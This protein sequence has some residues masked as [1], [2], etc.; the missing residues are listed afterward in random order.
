MTEV[1]KQDVIS[2]MYD[3]Q[4]DGTEKDHLHSPFRFTLE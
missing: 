3:E 1:K 2:G 4:T